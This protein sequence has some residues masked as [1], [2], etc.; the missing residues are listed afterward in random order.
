MS[1]EIEKGNI[2]E[3]SG[4]YYRVTS[5][6]GQKVNLGAIFGGHIYH[7]SIPVTQVREAEAEWYAKWQRSESYQCM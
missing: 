6:R 1:K 5:A 4:S 2:V 7:K 3:Y